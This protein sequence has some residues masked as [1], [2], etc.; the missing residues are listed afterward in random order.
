MDAP[1]RGLQFR[2][3]D[4][5][6]LVF[7]IGGVL[8]LFVPAIQ[9]A[10]EAARRMMC[11]NRLKQI[12]LG[13]LNYHDTFG[14]IPANY[15]PATPKLDDGNSWMLSLL[16]FIEQMNITQRML[17]RRANG[18]GAALES[19]MEETWK[20]APPARSRDSREPPLSGSCLTRRFRRSSSELSCVRLPSRTTA[21]SWLAAKAG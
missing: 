5:F 6:V 21:A 4:L 20:F 3:R 8:A 13:I 10:R 19:V 9:A 18:E 11:Q 16:P 7:V 17:E 12:G 1:R 14:K 2:L 15:G